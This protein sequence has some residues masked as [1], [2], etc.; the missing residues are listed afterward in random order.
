ML[1]HYRC[2]IVTLLIVP[3]IVIIRFE[4]EPEVTSI[5]VL[6]VLHVIQVF[7]VRTD[8]VI[9]LTL[10]DVLVYESFEFHFLVN[11]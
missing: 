1:F 7:N 10:E 5:E 6:V 2:H 11:I 3:Q 8:T 4:I 9:R